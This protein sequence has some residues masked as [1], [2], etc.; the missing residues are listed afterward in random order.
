[1]RIREYQKQFKHRRTAT[2]EGVMSYQLNNKEM[3]FTEENLRLYS[4]V[5]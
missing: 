4:G 2:F 1:M 3:Q 5:A